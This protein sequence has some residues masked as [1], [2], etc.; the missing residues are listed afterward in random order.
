MLATRLG[1]V[2]SIKTVVGGA[3]GFT[4][5]SVRTASTGYNEVLIRGIPW[6]IEYPSTITARDAEIETSRR[7]GKTITIAG[8]QAQLTAFKQSKEALEDGMKSVATDLRSTEVNAALDEIDARF[9]VR[10]RSLL[11]AQFELYMQA[12]TRSDLEFDMWI[13]QID[14]G[15]LWTESGATTDREM[16]ALLAGKVKPVAATLTCTR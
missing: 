13:Q 9:P 11:E 16:D 4:F 2:L 15:Y 3:T 14:D 1:E 7:E 12:R 5:G 8:K 10:W 6:Y